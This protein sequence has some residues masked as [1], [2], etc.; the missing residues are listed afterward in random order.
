[1]SDNLLTGSYYYGGT[2]TWFWGLGGVPLFWD[3]A[4]MRAL[5]EGDVR[6]LGVVFGHGVS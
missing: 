5:V 3:V 2:E 4:P 6:R 1:M